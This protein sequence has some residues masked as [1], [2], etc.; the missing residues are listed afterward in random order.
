M[1]PGSGRDII[2][3][4]GRVLRVTHLFPPGEKMK[5]PNEPNK[6]LK[7]MSGAKIEPKVTQKSIPFSG[8]GQTGPD[9]WQ[10]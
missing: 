7:I 10:K 3:P 1:E 4:R 5:W 8:F 9:R 6:L 2:A